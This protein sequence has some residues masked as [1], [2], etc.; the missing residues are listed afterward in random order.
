MRLGKSQPEYAGRFLVRR[1]KSTYRSRA[2]SPATGSLLDPAQGAMVRGTIP[3]SSD[4][5][6]SAKKRVEPE[7]LR[8]Q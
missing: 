7:G 8:F 6:R 3:S 5:A 4:S 2:L 1:S